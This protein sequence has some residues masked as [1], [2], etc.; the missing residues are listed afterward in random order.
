MKKWMIRVALTLAILVIVAY[1]LFQLSKS[2]TY[3]FIGELTDRVDTNEK[4]V[5]LTLDDG[6]TEKTDEVLRVLKEADVKA[7]FFVTG[8]E[9]Q[10]RPEEGNR[11]VQAGHE[12]GNH[13]YAHTRMVLKSPNFIKNEIEK[14]DQLIRDA[15]YRGEILFRPPNGKKL[16]LLPYYLNQHNRKTIMWDIEP[17]SYTDIGSNSDKIVQHVK[18]NVKPGSI[19]LL[20]VMYKN[21]EESLKSI[22]GIVESLRSQGYTFKTVSELLAEKK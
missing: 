12:L 9:L 10:Q 3:Q 17:D 16:L 4:V 2:R 21:R 18:E 13:S 11:I 20:H 15:G 6:P 14:T 8:A 5:A 1:G 19:I 7:T 22:K